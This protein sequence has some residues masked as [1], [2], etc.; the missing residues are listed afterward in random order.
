ME[1]TGQEIGT[2]GEFARNFP[3][4]AMYFTSLHRVEPLL[5]VGV[6]GVQELSVSHCLKL[7]LLLHSLQFFFPSKSSVS[8]LPKSVEIFL[9]VSSPVF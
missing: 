5:P 8:L 6:E 3:S 1:P 9:W 7:Q 4:I 2:A